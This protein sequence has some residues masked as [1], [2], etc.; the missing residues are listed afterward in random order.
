MT[1][2]SEIGEYRFTPG[3]ITKTLMADYSAGTKP[4]NAAAE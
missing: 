3:E 1:P 2:V 4:K